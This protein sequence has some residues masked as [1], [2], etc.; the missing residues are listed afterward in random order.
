M[1][2]MLALALSAL[3]LLAVVW[4]LLSLP[5]RL[6]AAMEQS[7]ARGRDETEAMRRHLLDM[8]RA[9]SAA[10]REA[11][12]EAMGRIFSEVGTATGALRQDVTGSLGALRDAQGRAIGDLHTALREGL[13]RLR[14]SSEARLAEIRT[15]VNEQLHAAVEKQMTESF[16]RVI[17]QFT[18]VQK[19]MSDVQAVTAQ[20]GDIKRLFSN[21]KTRG[22]WGEAQVRAMLD[23]VLPPGSYE[24]NKRLRD[25]SDEVVEFAVI[26]PM[27]GDRPVY[28]PIDAKFP[29]EDYERLLAASEAG[30]VEAERMAVAGLTRRIKD[31][32][33]KIATK[34][35][36]PPR[37]VEFAV[38]YV[39][40]D[41]LYAEIARVPGLIDEV[42]R[43]HRVLVL[44]PSVFPALLR[45]IHLGHV[46][47]A[48]EQKAD[49]I[50]TLLG[51]TKTE[52]ERMDKV[53]ERLA[54]QAGT[55]S[56]TIESARVRT[57]AVA[58]T[59]RGVEGREPEEAERLLATGEAG[60]EEAE[61]GLF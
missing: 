9:L 29:V 20:I 14:E 34:Y 38:L 55:F 17:D 57:R 39:P 22:G 58:R 47:L 41:A 13:D 51:A 11:N 45:T 12:T 28:L 32:A 21:V 33:R 27:K 7:D 18:A 44:G 10:L 8:E 50:R 35:V 48:L 36:L 16:A 4:I 37:T 54:K 19:A 56:N 15:A 61:E 5:S 6:A 46:T 2:D 49:Q 3:A 24:T 42:G 52:M 25:D 53:L 30:D 43:L 1:M 23:D 60:T 31:E 40:T 59:L 26:M